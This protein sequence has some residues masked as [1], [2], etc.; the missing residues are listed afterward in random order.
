MHDRDAQ[1]GRAWAGLRL[2]LALVP[3]VERQLGITQVLVYA[4]KGQARADHVD[5][6]AGLVVVPAVSPEG[7]A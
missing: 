6:P 4:R 7:D 5:V 2:L 3:E 1:L